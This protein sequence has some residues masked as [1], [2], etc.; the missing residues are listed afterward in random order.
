MI[1]QLKQTVCEAY[2]LDNAQWNVHVLRYNVEAV[3]HKFHFE[4]KKTRQISN[5]EG[6][7][8]SWGFR[9]FW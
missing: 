3:E 5:A 6:F 4:L 8:L 2:F 1:L 9:A 7:A